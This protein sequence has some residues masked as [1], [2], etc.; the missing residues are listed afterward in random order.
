MTPIT[1]V[2][3]SP[4]GPRNLP[5]T[6]PILKKILKTLPKVLKNPPTLPT[7]LDTPASGLNIFLINP[8]ILPIALFLPKIRLKNPVILL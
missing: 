8:N 5:M 1:I 3:T 6:L 7:V 2:R 4:I